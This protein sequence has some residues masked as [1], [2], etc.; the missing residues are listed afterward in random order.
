MA[1]SVMEV[2]AATLAAA[3]AQR[4][5]DRFESLVRQAKAFLEEHTD[6]PPASSRLAASFQI[7]VEH[8]RR[9]FKQHT[10]LSPYQYYFQLRINRAKHMLRGTGLTIKEIAAA[11]RF[12]NPYHFS[13]AF[14][15]KVGVSPSQ[16]RK[17]D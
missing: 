13:Q 16:W 11:L 15:K 6:D 10:G 2:L 3:K 14:K 9:L 7:S 4:G 5:A 17:G 1:V 8:F 12:E